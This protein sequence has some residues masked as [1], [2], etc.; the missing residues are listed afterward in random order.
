MQNGHSNETTKGED[1]IEGFSN[2][3][4]Q[5]AKE[6]LNNYKAHKRGI[7]FHEMVKVYTDWA[8]SYDQVKLT[9]VSSQYVML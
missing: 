1:G 2:V 3:T 5:D 7:S 4:E 6:Y 8:K 9:L